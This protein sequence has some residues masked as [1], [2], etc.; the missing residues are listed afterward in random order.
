MVRVKDMG[1][2]SGE[3]TLVVL[4][5]GLGAFALDVSSIKPRS[6]ACEDSLCE[7]TSETGVSRGTP[8]WADY[9]FG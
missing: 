6:S 8:A 5:H 2:T 9:G 3:E 1:L 4:T 7:Q